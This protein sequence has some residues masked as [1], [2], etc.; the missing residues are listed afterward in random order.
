MGNLL[1]CRVLAELETHKE[2]AEE[3]RTRDKLIPFIEEMKGL[4]TFSPSE[5]EEKIQVFQNSYEQ[6]GK[7]DPLILEVDP[8]SIG[9]RHFAAIAEVA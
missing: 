7:L 9:K 4:V 5:R 3:R 6:G 1:L 8:S 2:I